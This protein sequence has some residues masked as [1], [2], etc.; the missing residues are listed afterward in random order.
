MVPQL[1]QYD[2]SNIVDHL[3]SYKYL[4]LLYSAF[5][6]ILCKVFPSTLPPEGHQTVIL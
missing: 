2:V 6:A 1:D 3:E 5:D 4:M